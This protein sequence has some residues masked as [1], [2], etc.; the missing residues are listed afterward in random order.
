MEIFMS[1]VVEGQAA[2][3]EEVVAKEQVNVDD[4]VSRME[5]LENSNK[6]LLEESK[7]WKSKYQSVRTEVDQK[8]TEALEQSN[9][10]KGLY[11]KSQS[12]ISE[13]KGDLMETK[14]SSLDTALKFE[15][16]KHGKDAEDTEILLAA[17]KTKQRANL[18]FDKES[19]S[20][21]GVDLAVEELR[22]SN[23]GLF[24]SE[25]PGMISG[26]PG[27]TVPKEKTVDELIADDPNSVLEEALKQIL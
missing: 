18:G 7:T 24:R 12:T 2:A 11:E 25:V 20:W 10:F 3:P 16:A 27:S 26:R 21:V 23:P 4:I 22:K 1:E 8:E 9:D 15:V 5:K 19:S 6:R 17:V 14:K 13:L